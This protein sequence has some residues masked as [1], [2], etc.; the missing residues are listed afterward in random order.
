[1]KNNLLINYSVNGIAKTAA[2]SNEDIVI[3]ENNEKKHTFISITALKDVELTSCTITEEHKYNKT[4]RFF[5]N[6]YQ[7]WTD[8]F[9]YSFYHKLKDSSKLPAVLLKKYAFD[10]YGDSY[11][12]KYNKNVL[13]A[14]DVSY[15]TGSNSLF[16]GNNNYKTAYL[17]IEYHKKNNRLVLK[18]DLEGISLKKDQNLTVFDFTICSD[19]EKGKEEYFARFEKPKAEKLFGYT[20]WYNHYQD[21]NE[22]IILGALNNSTEHFDLFQID[23][24]FETFVGDWLSIDS[25]KFPNGLKPIVEKAHSKNMKAGIWL[26]PFAAEEK[27]ELF[28]NHKDWFLKDKNGNAVKCGSNWSGFYALDIGNPEAV[29]YIKKTLQF[30]KDLG[31][32]FFK[33]D[34]LYAASVIKQPGLSRSQ[35]AQKAY[36][37]LRN[38]LKDKLILGCGAVISNSFG[39]FDY[40]RIGPDVSLIFDDVWYMR[41]LHRERISTKVTLRN[42]I[43]R[44]LFDHKVFLNDPDVFLLR[45]HN[46]KLSKPQREALT[47]INSLFGSL[48]MTSDNPKH[49]KHGEDDF[50]K[51]ALQLFKYGSVKEVKTDDNNIRVTYELDGIEKSFVYSIK[52]GILIQEA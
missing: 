17:I 1:M 40:L 10:K 7:S 29:S 18:S 2:A 4:D 47:T 5:L 42:T 37:L 25:K 9:E 35:T 38:E 31:F 34:F 14:F 50:L 26:A 21:I 43:Y 44:H 45:S 8:S 48:L 22:D 12:H 39:M 32:D 24:G 6:G 52:K 23:D 11:F 49:Y 33:L 13:H 36:E 30:Y 51:R 19:I 3:C 20:S 41:H 28:K 15:I 16:I 46:I 27:S